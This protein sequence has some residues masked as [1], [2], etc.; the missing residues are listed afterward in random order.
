MLNGKV[1]GFNLPLAE[2]SNLI[3]FKACKMQNWEA[4]V[5]KEGRTINKTP[6]IL[7]DNASSFLITHPFTF[8]RGQHCFH[9]KP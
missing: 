1:D 5:N 8:E 4:A 9:I 7:R 6:F 3:T 2:E